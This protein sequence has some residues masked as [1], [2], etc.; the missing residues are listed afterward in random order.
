[1]STALPSLFVRATRLGRKEPLDISTAL[2][3]RCDRYLGLLFL[4]LN[5]KA[6]NMQLLIQLYPLFKRHAA[7]L[8]RTP[9]LGATNHPHTAADV[10]ADS[11]EG[12]NT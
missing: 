9:R 2:P 10:A 11:S 3:S 5:I 8:G 7:R 1:M 6:P 4:F 12:T